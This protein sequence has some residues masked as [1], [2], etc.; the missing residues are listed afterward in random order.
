MPTHNRLPATDLVAVSDYVFDAAGRLTDLTHAKG[1]TAL[2]DYQGDEAHSYD[3]SG[4]RTNTGY[5][6]G[7]NNHLL[8][9]GV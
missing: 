1:A 2:A 4:N 5:S 3:E 7:T 8:S 6:T 9:D